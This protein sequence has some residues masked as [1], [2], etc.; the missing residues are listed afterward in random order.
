MRMRRFGSACLAVLLALL[1]LVP[2]FAESIP[3]PTPAQDVVPYDAEHPE[4]LDPDQLW[5]VSAILIDANSGNVIFEKNADE[6]RAIASTTKIMTVLLG[7]MTIDPDTTVTVNASA[8]EVLNR[9]GSIS[10]MSLKEGE[11]LSFLDLCYGTMIRS[12]NEGANAIA[13]AVSG[14]QEAFVDLMNEYA[15]VL[16]CTNTHFMN[17]N[18]LDQEGHYSTARDLALIAREAMKNETFREIVRS[19]SYTIP[20]TNML[21]AR[22]YTT[23]NR[24]LLPGSEEEPNKYYYPYAIGIKTGT[25]TQA[26][27]CLVGAAEKDGVELISV[28]LF[29]GKLNLWLD[30]IK[31]FNYGFA[32]YI[33]VTPV[34]IYNGNPVS[35]NMTGFSLNDPAMGV[36][37]LNCIPVDAADNPRI[38]VTTDEFEAMSHNLRSTVLIDYTRSFEAPITVGETVGT[39]TYFQ[40]DGTASEYELVA[41]RSVA[42]RENAPKTI[43]EI[44]A[45]TEADPNPLPDLSA[46]LVLFAL[47]PLLLLALIVLVIVLLVRRRRK[48]GSKVPRVRNRYLK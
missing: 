26:G 16:G 33:S 29:S 34:D 35:V 8:L 19:T 10:N 1:S 17:A 18:G 27:Y 14:S 15:Q 37:Q 6:P 12:A 45:E 23:S 3:E 4:L 2:A 47:S 32:H 20:R 36:V 11:E 42:R 41:S 13:E 43:A 5:A 46:E 40:E 44:V 7:L 9:E 25:E 22:S 38:T 21:R 30:N 24:L 31:L 28:T 39:M 48:R